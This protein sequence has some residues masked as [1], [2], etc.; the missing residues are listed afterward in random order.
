M[1]LFSNA[2]PS[3]RAGDTPSRRPDT[4]SLSIIATGTTV[5]GDIETPGVLKVEGRVQGTVRSQ[6]QI[7]VV[8][9]G[10]IEGDLLTREAIIG[11]DVFGTVQADDRVEIQASA[12]VHGDIVTQRIMIAEGGKVN[13]SVSMANGS[14][15]APL[16]AAREGVQ[17]AL[18][19]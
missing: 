2:P 3:P 19:G 18:E 6:S 9:G 7:L 1:G 5:V 4:P 12:T 15:S 17:A 16:P 13:G 8:K 11:G 14:A 10:V